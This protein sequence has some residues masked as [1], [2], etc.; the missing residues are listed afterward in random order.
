[1]YVS[2]K[3]KLI[4]QNLLHLFK[5]YFLF[6]IFLTISDV[7]THLFDFHNKIYNWKYSNQICRKTIIIIKKKT[8]FA[9]KQSDIY[10]DLKY[11]QLVIQDP[12]IYCFVVL[13]IIHWLL[14]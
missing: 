3:L 14:N 8:L 9:T 12:T 10:K 11:Y 4:Q 1:M 7:M 5:F 13:L 2:L 6:Y